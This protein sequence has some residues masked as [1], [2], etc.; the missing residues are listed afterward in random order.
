VVEVHKDAPLRP[1]IRILVDEFGKTF[2]QDDGDLVD[3]LIER[4]LFIARAIDP[5]EFSKVP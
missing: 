5:K 3:L 2:N 4:S 1:Q